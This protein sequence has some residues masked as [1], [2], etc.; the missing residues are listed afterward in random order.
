MKRTTLTILMSC[1][2]IISFGQNSINQKMI[3]LGKAYKDFMFRNDPSKEVIKELKQD[4]PD[5]LKVAT[6]FI[7]QTITKNNKIL[8][9]K[10]LTRPDDIVLKQ[11]YIIRAINLNLREETQIENNKLIDSLSKKEIPIY[12]LVDNY[13]EM[14]FGS[15]GNKNQPVDLSNVD[16]I[17]KEY[18]LKDDTEKGILVLKAISFCGTSIWGFM[19]IPKPANTKK[20]YQQ[21]KKFPKINGRPYYQY[22]D[23]Y[24]P[25]FE[26]IIVTNKGIQSYKNYYIDKCYETLLNHLICLNKEGGSE[27]EINDLLLGSILKEENLYKYTKHQQ[28]LKDLFKKMDRD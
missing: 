23:F 6:N 15:A 25:D 22:T 3:E 4:V 11:I 10:F 7:I 19:N 1:L 16:L 21:I 5:N 12:E 28:T 17:L 27:K 18:N 2:V 20:A 24:F 14:I 9:S 13:Y 26:M 8:T